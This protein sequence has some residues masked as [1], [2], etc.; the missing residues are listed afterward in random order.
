MQP[1]NALQSQPVAPV[2]LN[3][4]VSGENDAPQSAQT[5]DPQASTQPPVKP[6]MTNYAAAV[7]FTLLIVGFTFNLP[8]LLYSPVMF[9]CAVAGVLFFR[10]TLAIHKTAQAV[11]GQYSYYAA[12]AVPTKKRNPL[13]TLLLIILGVIGAGIILF[14]G[15]IVFIVIMLGVSGV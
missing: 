5:P 8:S 3:T 9:F 12:S 14:V 7:F 2:A 11:Q 10:D 13:I 6:T 1:D 15:F 4:V